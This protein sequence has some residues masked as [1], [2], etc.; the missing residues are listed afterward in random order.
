ME[1]LVIAI[2]AF[3]ASFSGSVVAFLLLKTP[4]PAP[5]KAILKKTQPKQKVIENPEESEYR[6]WLYPPPKEGV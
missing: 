6:S 4:A 5:V 1:Y 3:F 2:V